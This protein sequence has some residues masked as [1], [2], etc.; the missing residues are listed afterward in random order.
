MD[1]QNSK[2]V[3]IPFDL[4]KCRRVLNATDYAL[5]MLISNYC[6]MNSYCGVSD[7]HMSDTL[8]V[9]EK[10]I[11]RSLSKLEK[12]TFISIENKGHR[13]K[14]KVPQFS[15]FKDIDEHIY[16]RTGYAVD[17]NAVLKLVDEIYKKQ[18][19]TYP[20]FDPVEYAKNDVRGVQI[21]QIIWTLAKAQHNPDFIGI[22]LAEK[23][24]TEQLLEDLVTVFDIGQIAP[25]A[26]YLAENNEE[27]DNIDHYIL[28]GIINAHK[29]LLK[30][31][32]QE[33]K[34]A[35]IQ[36]SPEELEAKTK[37]ALETLFEDERNKHTPGIEIMRL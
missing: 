32:E 1:T 28:T 8:R 19:E 21:R 25:L 12:L 30:K 7:A 3:I 5:F 6:N 9:D 22:R 35:S 36:V 27:V 16:I 34:A 24:V 20:G 10:S 13:R 2:F 4:I 37:A 26:R 23:K 14:I 29:P 15:T 18:K 11:T 31:L 17:N 33:R